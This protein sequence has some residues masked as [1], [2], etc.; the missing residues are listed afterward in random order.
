MHIIELTKTKLMCKKGKMMD[1]HKPYEVLIIINKINNLFL[2]KYERDPILYY[3]NG[4]C[5]YYAKLLQSFYPRGK[6]FYNSNHVFIK[7][8][9]FYYD[10]RGVIPLSI[11]QKHIEIEDDVHEEYVKMVLSPK[12][13]L[14]DL[15]INEY[16]IDKMLASNIKSKKQLRKTFIM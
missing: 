14:S 15:K 3:M 6:L 4:H 1:N 7:I 5:Y 11:N 13:G 10:V 12:D 9:S 8:D 2:A 16:I